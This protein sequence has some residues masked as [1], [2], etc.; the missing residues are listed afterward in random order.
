MNN[1]LKCKLRTKEKMDIE[2]ITTKE[3]CIHQN[4]DENLEGTEYQQS[5]EVEPL[6]HFSFRYL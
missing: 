5:P 3:A 6:L 4:E 2:H 1:L